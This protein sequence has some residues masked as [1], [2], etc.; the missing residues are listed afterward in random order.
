MDDIRALGSVSNIIRLRL[1]DKTTQQGKTGLTI[2]TSGLIISTICDNE[3]TSV[4]Y[5]QAASKIETIAA[6]GTFVAPTATKCRFKEVDAVNHPGLCEL[7]LDNARFAVA[8]AKQLHITINDA[9]AT[10]LDEGYDIGFS[11]PVTLADGVAH[12]GVTATLALASANITNPAGDA[13]TLVGTV[14]HGLVAIGQGGGDAIHAVV[15]DGN[16]AGMFLSGASGAASAALS[17]VGTPSILMATNNETD[18]FISLAGTASAGIVMEDVGVGI[19]I[20][21]NAS[22]G[23]NETGGIV[24]RSKGG[25]A[26]HCDTTGNQL[27]GSVTNVFFTTPIKINSP[28]H[29]LETGDVV[30]VTGVTGNTGAN[31]TFIVTRVDND[32]FLLNGST[33]TSAYTGGGSW[34]S[35]SGEALS[36]ASSVG[37]G[38]YV[39]GTGK[40]LLLS[41]TAATDALS[42]AAGAGTPIDIFGADGSVTAALSLADFFTVNTTK[43]YADAISGSVVKE[44][45]ANAGGAGLTLADFFVTDSTKVYADAIDG[46]VVKEIASNAGGTPAESIVIHPHARDRLAQAMGS[47]PAADAFIRSLEGS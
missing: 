10:I 44:I 22:H 32:N 5:T 19:L 42:I 37:S 17:L 23:L 15:G 33:R 30:T 28:G 24:I 40:A 2:S 12:G 7:Q 8:S 20:N 39:H 41:G 46:S 13:L 29:F 27:S 6:I 25:H 9:E 36:V 47:K 11:P 1:K 21:S 4:S 18:V 38:A 45:A 14:G 3:N 16:G 35:L 34:A 26:I 31:G 43:T